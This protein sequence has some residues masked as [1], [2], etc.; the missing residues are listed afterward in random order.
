MNERN[1][2]TKVNFSELPSTAYH[3]IPKLDDKGLKDQL[4]DLYVK[5][6]N[7]YWPVDKKGLQTFRS[8]YGTTLKHLMSVNIPEGVDCKIMGRSKGNGFI[9]TQV[10]ISR[11]DRNEW[12][13]CILYQPLAAATSTVILTADEG[14]NRW[15]KA[16]M[17]TPDDV[18]IKLL[19]QRSNVLV[20]DLFKQG[21]HVLQSG[22]MT[23]RDEKGR[24]FTTYNLTDRQQ[25]AQ[26]ILTIVK[27][28]NINK[29]LS[30]NISLYAT[31]NSGITG[32]LLAPLTN[33]L[34]KIAL[35][36]DHF[37]PATD[38]NMLAVKV[39]GILR[40]GGLKTVLAL[41]ANKKL[42]L[43]NADPSLVSSQIA[44]VS[45]LDGNLNFVITAENANT[46]RI[47][48]FFKN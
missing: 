48:G 7:Q 29:D 40:I 13:P 46:E 9:A 34:S 12:I 26:D 22:T 2:N 31:G 15:V 36:G 35:D 14:K 45:K 20:P 42:I 47:A 32:L 27:A 30:Q 6:L 5:Q 16:G 3:D 4:K 1:S 28:I 23:R 41:A 21:E 25:Q 17:N 19:T 10:L 8:T 24:F 37:D 38:Q 43:Y 39:P 44:A 18:I 11:K 33:G